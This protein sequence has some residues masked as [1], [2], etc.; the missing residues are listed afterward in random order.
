MKKKD[1]ILFVCILVFSLVAF[2]TLW[3]VLTPHG[4]VAV[5]SVDGEEYARLPLRE[6]TELLVSTEYGENLVVVRDGAVYISEADC[7]DKVCVKTGKAN[8]MKSVVCA[9]HRLTV[10]VETEAAK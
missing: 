3:L 10:T 9:P 8:A 4:D 5:V 1:I 2:F 6:D 7:P